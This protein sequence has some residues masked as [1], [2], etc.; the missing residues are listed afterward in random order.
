MLRFAGLVAAT[1]LVVRY[2]VEGTPGR[3]EATKDSMGAAIAVA[4]PA[5]LVCALA[6]LAFSGPL[7]MAMLAIALSIPGLL[8]QDSIRFAFFAAGRPAKAAANDLIWAC[9]QAVTF[10]ALFF[11][12]DPSA[13]LLLLAWGLAATVAAVAGPFQARLCPSPLRALRWF[14]EQSDLAGRYLLDFF[15]L[16]GQVHLLLYGL[17]IVVGLREFG[18]FRAAQLILGPLNTLYF[19]ALSAAVPEGARIRADVDGSL[20]RMIRFLAI[21]LPLIALVWVGVLI[22]LPERTGTAM[23][24]AS[25]PG[26]HGLI[27]PIG[28]AIA[29]TGVVAAA[30]AGLR[31]LAAARRGLRARLALLPL[32]A[33]GGLGGA[34]GGG[35]FG[36]AIGLFIANSMGAAIFWFQF[37]KALQ[38]EVPLIG[39][40]A[41]VPL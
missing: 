3:R 13:A 38:E 39:P 17:G 5:A 20:H 36:C 22:L 10:T 34:A 15:A 23:L 26:A 27:V 1:P 8:V 33:I 7:R 35:A 28:L 41:T 29:V 19:A 14:Q 21:V 32:V 9:A 37:S 40:A 4:V 31:A 24:G 11:L 6:G 25:W 18:A 16:A 2:S 30:N 12:T